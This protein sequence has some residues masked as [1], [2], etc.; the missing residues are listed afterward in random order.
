MFC[1]GLHI[2][3]V[4]RCRRQ[5]EINITTHLDIATDYSFERLIWCIGLLS[6]ASC[7]TCFQYQKYEF[8]FGKGTNLP[9]I[10]GNELAPGAHRDWSCTPPLPLPTHHF[11]I[12]II[13]IQLIARSFKCPDTYCIFGL[14]CNC[15]G[16]TFHWKQ[17]S[18]SFE[19][20]KSANL[21]QIRLAIR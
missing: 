21:Y 16:F 6:K 20:W 3:P 19:K 5:Q 2:F 11:T 12:S 15:F 1:P 13:V 8:F 17:W 7:Q 9:K 4:F 18:Y 14:C 10:G